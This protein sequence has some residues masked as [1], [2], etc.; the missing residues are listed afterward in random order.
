MPQVDIG[1]IMGSDSDL[2]IMIQ[3][4]TILDYF[5]ITYEFKILSAHRSPNATLAYASSAVSR[6]LKVLIAGAGG[7]A[8]LAGVIASVTPLPVIGVPIGSRALGGVDALYAMVQMP[9]GVPVATMAVD[10]AAN[11][12]LMAVKII[13]VSDPTLQKK[14]VAF[15]EKLAREVR[16]KDERLAQIGV[17]SYL[18]GLEN[19]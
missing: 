10:G 16:A 9:K 19:D 6:G 12:A 8:H 2:P 11:G 3:A 13:A 15:K 1:I 7:A 14:V 4:A 5:Q 18:R 17:T